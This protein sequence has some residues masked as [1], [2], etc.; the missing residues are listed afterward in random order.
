[1]RD[2]AIICFWVLISTI[3][4][5]ENIIWYNKGVKSIGIST[6][7]DKRKNKDYDW[8][9]YS[10]PIGNGSLGASI[11]SSVSTERIIFNEKTLWFG[12][13]NTKE[14]P[15]YYWDVNKPAAKHLDKIRKMFMQGNVD[16]ATKLTVDNFNGFGDYS[17]YI[18]KPHR[19]GN[20]TTAGE[21]FIETE[22][23]EMEVS[24]FYRGLSIDSSY[25]YT[26][27]TLNN[28]KYM[29]KSFIS[30]PNNVMA[31]R[32]SSDGDAVQNLKF[33]YV[34]NPRLKGNFRVND[35]DEFIY[36]AV[37]DDNNL[38]FAIRVKAISKGGLVKINKSGEIVIS[39]S[40]ETTFLITADTDYKINFDPDFADSLT[41]VGESPEKTTE[42]WLNS[43]VSKGF[44][45]LYKSHYSDYSSLYNRSSIIINKEMLYQANV[46]TLPF[47]VR[48]EEYKKGSMDYELE[49]MYFNYGRYLL[50]SSS[51]PGNMPA[52]L[53][54]I[55]HNDIDGPWRVD[56]HNNINVQMNYWPAC[57]TNL[58]EC[59]I[60]YIDYIRTLVKPGE[61]TAKA[62]YN[63]DGWTA[64]ISGNIFGF[65]APL[66]SKMMKWNLIPAAGPWL[67]IDVWNY[68]D[69]T[70]DLKFLKNIGYDIIRGSARF[71]VDY[72][73]KKP[74]GKYA[75]IPSSS[76]EH[77]PIDKG[78]TFVH[79][80]I[81]ELLSD[82]VKASKLLDIDETER[83][84]WQEVL[85]NIEPYKIGR[86]GQLMEWSE[87]IDDP[88]DDHRHVNH[89]F[90]LHPG[91]TISP[92]KTPELAEASRIVLNHRGD[93]ATGWSMGWKL[94]LWARLRDGNKAYT[95]YRNLLKDG[96]NKN[97]WCS[98]PPF[99]IDGNLGGTAGI[100]EMLI[101][102]H[103]GEIDILPSLPNV[104]KTGELKGIKTRGNFTVDVNWR[105]YEPKIIRIKSG[106]GGLCKVRFK[107]EVI[108][109][110]TKK[111][112]IYDI[113]YDGKVLFIKNKE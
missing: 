21:F 109:F 11:M 73:W 89:L 35:K 75:A 61:K 34:N 31:I 56:Y 95:L 42:K 2:I 32:F 45:D 86:Y 65:T 90:G 50:I 16:M 76:P 54:G 20:Y 13:P 77:G 28:V 66:T 46:S 18:E 24:N 104:W 14:G 91:S 1:M 67:A 85:D 63:A 47:D 23:E 62:Y 69:Y 111:G 36:S 87:D 59:E 41:Y 74:N 25:V 88:N 103:M 113:G 6:W 12:G 49:T 92:I 96:T 52:N 84:E 44:E 38:K 30:Y 102:S 108:V 4:S 70:R 29:R 71:A 19:F 60:P 8:E 97:M 81:K 101:Q 7:D 78:V 83:K 93:G 48:L 80:V 9:N 112:D 26:S 72:M 17:P 39:N 94:N 22:H 105:N 33:R 15:K 100:V 107:E 43:A 3:V 99:Q 53:Q 55:W 79:A 58:A 68:Y 106:A 5:A 64:S 110:N 37:L 98:H 10:L 51:R 40:T 27:Y 57:V 82:A